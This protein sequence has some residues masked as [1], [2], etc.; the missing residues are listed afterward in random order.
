MKSSY[1]LLGLRPV[2]GLSVTAVATACA[3]AQHE[4]GR[5]KE[6][7]CIQA[8]RRALMFLI[9]NLPEHL[10]SQ[11]AGRSLALAHGMHWQPAKIRPESIRKS[12]RARCWSW[13]S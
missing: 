5:S 3:D 12:M 11:P 9:Q 1:W 2:A 10:S 13:V 6:Q 7:R 8:M 4:L